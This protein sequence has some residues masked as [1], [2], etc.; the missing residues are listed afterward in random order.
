MLMSK[1][2]KYIIQC[3]DVIITKVQ[4]FYRSYLCR[5]KYLYDNN[6]NENIFNKNLKSNYYVRVKII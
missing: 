1:R 2:Y 4:A 5:K 6:Y 3:A